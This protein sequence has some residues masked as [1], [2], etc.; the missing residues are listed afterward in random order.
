MILVQSNTWEA[1][2]RFQA[3][4]ESWV[5]EYGPLNV[6]VYGD[7]T[8]DSRHSSADRTDWHIVREFF[9]RL[10]GEYRAHFNVP[11]QNPSVKGRVNAVNAMVCSH[12]GQR[13]LLVDPKCR[14]L[15]KDFERVCWKS[16]PHGNLQTDLDK[17]DPM[18][19]HV[20]DAMGYWVVHKHPLRDSG[21]PRSSSIIW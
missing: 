15:I 6:Y 5:Q 21:G 1:C 8:G 20:S 10:T 2:Q 13:R 7:A 12:S 19:T 17:S 18:R 3:K 11:S 14:E 16:D 9:S 4:T